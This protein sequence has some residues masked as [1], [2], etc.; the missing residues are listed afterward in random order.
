M[1]K[2]LWGFKDPKE[3]EKST[4]DMPDSILKEQIALLA[5]KTNYVL[6]G[7]PTFIKVR[8]AEIHFKVATVFDVVVPALDSYSKTLLIMYSNPESEFPVAISVG[9]SYE[10]DCEWFSPKY[11]CNNKEEFETS[12][13]EI[14][15]SDEVLH[16]IQI[17]YSKASMLSN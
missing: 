7:K 4:Q 11:S 6:H 9:S 17:L 2:D 5:E 3:L 15:S 10:E 12:I 13:R 8:S 1:R 16:I 14:L